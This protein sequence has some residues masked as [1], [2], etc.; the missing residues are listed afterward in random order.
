MRTALAIAVVAALAVLAPAAATA[1]DNLVLFHSVDHIDATD[2]FASCGVGLDWSPA[3]LEFHGLAETTQ[4][5]SA[6]GLKYSSVVSGD[7][8]IYD[9]N[10]DTTYTGHLVQHEM[11]Q[12][13]P[14]D[15][16]VIGA[17][18]YNENVVLTAPD[19]SHFSIHVLLEDTFTP[20]FRSSQLEI[21]NC[22][23]DVSVFHFT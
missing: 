15:A 5:Y 1:D 19:G 20:T 12:G 6:T 22:D 3:F 8:T 2:Q 4:L 13:N 10:T 17:S 23:G 18:A 16:G 11:S 7:V 14:A 9:P 21:T